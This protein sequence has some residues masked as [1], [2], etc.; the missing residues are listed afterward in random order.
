MTTLDDRLFEATV[1]T[2]ELFGVYLGT[3]L[4][5]YRVMSERGPLR[6]PS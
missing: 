6:P 5:L 3:R 2:L 4:G 1:G